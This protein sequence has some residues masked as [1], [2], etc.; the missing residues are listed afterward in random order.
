MLRS[1]SVSA[2]VVSMMA[3]GC[4]KAA[5]QQ[6]KANSAQTEADQKIAAAKKDEAEKVNGAQTEADKKV[7]GAQTEADKKVAAA[8]AT[9]TKLRDDY[10]TKVQGDLVV[11]DKK[12]DDLDAKA[13]ARTGTAKTDLVASLAKV[14]AQRDA[15][16]TSFRSLDATSATSWDDAKARLDVQLGDLKTA[17]D[18]AT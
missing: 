14:H 1:I 11:L 16:A 4:D 7:N 3:M 15:F 13:K 17:V 12:V 2:L 8:Q 9:F 18:K 5:D 6:D 10:R